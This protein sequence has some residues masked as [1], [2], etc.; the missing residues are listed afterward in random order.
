MERHILGAMVKQKFSAPPCM[1]PAPLLHENDSDA[2]SCTNANVKTPQN[3]SE[4]HEC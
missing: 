1:D 4:A 3:N 2:L